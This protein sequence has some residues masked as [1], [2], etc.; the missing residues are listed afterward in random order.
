MTKMHRWETNPSFFPKLTGMY[1][2]SNSNDTPQQPVSRLC[3]SIH[4]FELKLRSICK[5]DS[6]VLT[7]L[8]VTVHLLF[9]ATLSVSLYN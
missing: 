8:V 1:V 7:A 4:E 2:D 6:I 9:G 3:K 5:E